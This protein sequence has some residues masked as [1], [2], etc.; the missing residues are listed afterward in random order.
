[1]QISPPRIDYRCILQR[2]QTYVKDTVGQHFTWRCTNSMEKMKMGDVQPD[3]HKDT[4]LDLG[5]PKGRTLCA[6]TPVL[7]PHPHLVTAS[8]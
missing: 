8:L 4:C 3:R 6:T 5:R 7:S 2:R 1:M